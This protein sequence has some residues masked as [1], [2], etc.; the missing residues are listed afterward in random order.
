MDTE[1]PLH[2][3]LD[4]TVL[5]HLEDLEQERINFG[6]YETFVSA[7]EILQ[8]SRVRDGE[9]APTPEE[10][11]ASLRRLCAHHLALVVKPGQYRSRISEIVRLLKNLK[12]LWR[13]EQ[14]AEAPF[15]IQSVRVRFEDRKRL[16]WNRPLRPAMQRLF[17][18][19]RGGGL[20]YLDLACRAVRE[21]FAAAIRRPADEV[22]VTRVQEE[23]ILQVGRSYL[24]RTGQGYV[25]TGNTGSGK[26]EAALLPLLI[27]ALQEKMAA[28]DGCKVLL[29]YPR[30]ALAKNQLERLV[31]YVA[32]VNDLVH[33]M[34]GV[35]D[36]PLTLG[37]VFG[38][39]PH[40]EE[41]LRRGAFAGQG[42]LVRHAWV[43]VAGGHVLP[44][45]ATADGSAVHALDLQDGVCTLQPVGAEAKPPWRLEGF[46]ATRQAIRKDP[47]DVLIITTEMLH[48]WLTDP[49]FNGFFGLP[50][51]RGR[52]PRRCAPRAV[53]FDE[54]HLYD[55]THGAQ[56]G[57]LLRRLR[58]RLFQAFRACPGE[59][60]RYPLVIGMSA[61]IGHPERFWQHLSGVPVVTPLTPR[62]ED[63]GKAVGR[64]YFLF[65]RPETYSRGQRVGDGT[66]AILSV[67]AIA[68]NMVRRAPVGGEPGKFRGLVFQDSIGKLK[69]LTVEFY[70]AETNH[71]RAWQ[72]L[73]PVE[74][75]PVR[76][77]RFADGE[78]W[79]FDRHDPRQYSLRRRPA[80]EPVRLT[81]A[82]VPVYSATGRRAA[83]VLQKDIIFATT[84]LEVGYDDPSIQLVLQ[85]HAPRN[86]ASF[87]QKKGRAGRS[88]RDRPI[89][90]VT[91]SHHFFQDTFYFQ[92]P[93]LLF[94]PADYDPALNVENYFVQRFQALAL[95]FD[96]L[97]R[98]TGTD[99]LRG[100]HPSLAEHL[101]RIEAAVAAPGLEDALQ[102]AY[103]VVLATS[104]RRLHPRWRAVWDW[105]RSRMGQDDIR[106]VPSAR[107]LL[108]RC[109][110]L[111]TNLF[112]TINLPTVQV[113][114]RSGA[115][116]KWDWVKEDLALAFAEVAPGRVT[117]RYGP[118]W[119]H[120]LFW[121][122]PG[123]IGRLRNAVALERYKDR[124]G[125]PG[126]FDPRLLQPLEGLWGLDWTHYLPLQVH[127]LYEGDLPDRFYRVRFIE[128]WNF[129]TLDP[130]DP[131]A[132]QPDW[133]WFGI[134]QTDGSV[135][136]R[137]D[138]DGSFRQD[139]RSRQVLPDSASVPLSF[140]VVAP[141]DPA[142]KGPA[143]AR[144][145][146]SL[147][148]LFRGLAEEVE[149]Y[150]GEAGE[151]RSLLRL[152]E[153]HY[154]AEATIYL[155]S[156]GARDAHAGI[157]HNAIRYVSEHDGRPV[158]YGHD[159][160][161]EGLRVCCPEDRLRSL[162][163]D[164]L[165]QARADPA[166]SAHVQ[167]QYLRFLLK[168]HDW[169]VEGV[170]QP[171]TTFDRRKVADLIATLRADSRH[172]SESLNAFLDAVSEP[173]GLERLLARLTAE[174]WRDHRAV[175]DPDFQARLLSTLTGPQA[176]N[177]LRDVFRRVQS[178]RELQEYLMDT[179][180]HSLEHAMRNLVL[181]EGC[182]R[183]EEIGSHAMLNLTYGRRSPESSFYVHERNQGGN[184]ATRL[185]AQM[186]QERGQGYLLQRWW[187]RAL[188]CPV[189]DEEDFLRYML[190]R[191]AAELSRF[192]EEF[193]AAAPE[194][195]RPPREL[196]VALT[197]GWMPEGDTLLG[198]LAGLLTGELSFAGQH[199]PQ[200]GVV[201]EILR[202]EGELARRFQRLPTATELAGTAAHAAERQPTDYPSLWRLY[203]IYQ[204]HARAASLD[205]DPDS[206]AHPLD[207]FLA[208]VEHLSL[209]TCVDACPACLATG[210][211]QGPIDVTRH[212]LSRRQLKVAHRL[213]SAPFTRTYGQDAVADLVAL[214]ARHGGHLILEHRGAADPAVMLQ[215][216][217]AGFEGIGRILEYQDGAEPL[218]RH[219]LH[220]RGAT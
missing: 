140:C 202:L 127:R 91:L 76:S 21:G 67:M 103:E 35:S 1:S 172:R 149:F 139:P 49:S 42:K 38:D 10:L 4:W 15:V 77:P 217:D 23:A 82:V 207:R 200:L 174:Y 18:E 133:H 147:P 19:H 136:L 29:V 166:G 40:R 66:T 74:G 54:V 14:A 176:R 28:V 33:A 189:G 197:R 72:R 151:R 47:P 86:V 51:R 12:R 63:L 58:H 88:L 95:L 219:A 164:L 120:L 187:D 27:G 69:K 162:A 56:V 193:F 190:R 32:A 7:A 65:I 146:F 167:D 22:R 87:V 17:E 71:F 101:D 104:F 118:P 215:L 125:Q 107:S 214:A 115:D 90:A 184:G 155:K 180:L 156:K 57:L 145:V 124:D 152:Y 105:F 5:G 45:F 55:S 130:A 158:L 112:G 160:V 93:Q 157:G 206:A 62:P 129:G 126:P 44:Y 46:K 98:C 11:E 137:Y 138:A 212:A 178:L 141:Y 79:Y 92:N 123:K 26:T 121:R 108:E 61:T 196:L 89:T 31:R 78:Y 216:R 150:F 194:D 171:L 210:C 192:A 13:A 113:M 177:H 188:A 170:G 110:D 134:R 179:V 6:L 36:R 122:A 94:D 99:F 117:R 41:D 80:G 191:H 70:D 81:S 109:P 144:Q 218:V 75:D 181:T 135:D 50:A 34:R 201:L 199:L 30:Q 8:R 20:R 213:L 143:P 106:Y 186:F 198:R 161:T 211:G 24:G 195:R 2:E 154:G 111:P 209:A 114:C 119:K 185:V 173:A 39:T 220:R 85:H 97:A 52:A 165:A 64:E 131:T 16:E 68:H 25:I 59:E 163:A 43:E 116:S 142:A 73:Q 100:Q 53:V 132:P 203:D 3:P 148:P 175:A 204:E 48:R 205:D 60:W 84:A 183:D 96:E 9:S 128:L 102:T 159:V 182:A 153:V 83:S 37:I 168:F 169:P 208:Q